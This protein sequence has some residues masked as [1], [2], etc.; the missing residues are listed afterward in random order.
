MLKHT[1]YRPYIRRA[2]GR[3][4][5]ESWRCALRLAFYQQRGKPFFV[6]VQ[7]GFP[8][9]VFAVGPSRKQLLDSFVGAH[10]H[11]GGF[12]AWARRMQRYATGG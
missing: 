3:E 11:F 1:R 2:N 4:R 8:R 12:K 6:A 7:R 10:P 5:S 9:N